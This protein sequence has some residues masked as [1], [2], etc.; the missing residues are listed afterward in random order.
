[1]YQSNRIGEVA[2]I[3]YVHYLS[4]SNNADVST[5]FAVLQCRRVSSLDPPGSKETQ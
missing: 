1:M 3:L 2:G 5:Q 4:S